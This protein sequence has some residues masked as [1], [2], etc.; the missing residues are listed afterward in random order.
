[1]ILEGNNREEILEAI[2]MWREGKGALRTPALD[3]YELAVQRFEE[4]PHASEKARLGFAIHAALDL[5]REMRRIAD[6]P[7]ALRALQ[8]YGRL[9]GIYGIDPMS[10]RAGAEAAAP[11]APPAAPDDTTEGDSVDKLLKLIQGGN[12]GD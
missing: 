11:T 10:A 3:I 9:T 7:G 1:M 4:L 2:E 6:Y 8:E 12:G 5:F